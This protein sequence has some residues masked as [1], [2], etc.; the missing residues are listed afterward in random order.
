MKLIEQITINPEVCHGKPTIR[1]TR[2]M[3]ES[4]LEYMAAGDSIDDILNEFTD[5]TREDI[6]A[7]LSYAALALKFKDIELPA[8]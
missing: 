2:Y 6:L 7:C 3:V 4:I 5:L 8:A 1:N